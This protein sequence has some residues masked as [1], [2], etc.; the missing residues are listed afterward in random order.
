ML[1]PGSLVDVILFNAAGGTIVGNEYS[2]ANLTAFQTVGGIDAV[3]GLERSLSANTVIPSNT[4]V[5][6]FNTVE[7]NTGGFGTPNS[8]LGIASQSGLHQIAGS[9]SVFHTNPGLIEGMVTINGVPYERFAQSGIANSYRDI[10]FKTNALLNPGDVVAVTLFNAAGGN[11]LGS[12]YSTGNLLAYNVVPEPSSLVLASWRWSP[13]LYVLGVELVVASV[14]SKHSGIG[15]RAGDS[16]PP[17]RSYAAARATV[18][19]QCSSSTGRQKRGPH[20]RRHS[21][22]RPCAGLRT[23]RIPARCSRGSRCLERSWPAGRSR[24][25]RAACLPA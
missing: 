9:L 12:R 23:L 25:P 5:V 16:L 17:S 13:L 7:L 22:D 15:N 3:E 14:S 21:V 24:S 6:P 19:R 1:N 2:Q 10:G 8:V 4:F 18:L 20:R 11:L